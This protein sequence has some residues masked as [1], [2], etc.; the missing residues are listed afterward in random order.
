MAKPARKWLKLFT[1]FLE[2]LRIESKHESAE[3]EEKGIKLN[4]WESQQRV[5]D[6]IGNGL[7]DGVHVF[8]I[9]KSRQLGVSTVTLAILLFWAL[10]HP[11]INCAMVIDNEENSQKFRAMITKYFE[12]FPQNYFG[13]RLT[14]TK[15][16]SRT[17]EFSN[18]SS[19]D[20]LVAG[21]SKTTWGE[22]RAYTAALLSEVSKYGKPEGLNSFIETLSETNPIRLYLYESTAHGPNHWRDMWKDAGKDVY[23]K[24]PVFIGWWSSQ[25]NRFERKDPRFKIF[26]SSAPSPH[27]KEKI[28]AVWNQ[29]NFKVTQE[30]LAWYRWR[31]SSEATTQD[32]LDEQQPWTEEEAFVI[33]AMSF[34][35]VREVSKDIQRVREGVLFMGF[36]FY[37]G[38][39]FLSSTIDQ[40][41]EQHQIHE[42]ELRVWEGPVDQGRYAIGMDVAY[43][44]SEKNDS[45]CVSV[46][47]CFANK[48]VQVAEYT[49][50]R[51]S[52]QQ[53]AWVLAYL[54][55]RYRNCMVN[56]EVNGPGDG[57]MAEINSLRHQL[58]AEEYNAFMGTVNIDSSMLDCL[59]WYIYRRPDS[60]GPGFIFNFNTTFRTKLP[61]IS[62]FR[63]NHITNMLIINSIPCLE[64][65][66]HVT[67]DG[68]EVGAAAAGLH[69]DRVFAAAL[70]NDTWNK[71][72]RP[73]MMHQNLTYEREMNMGDPVKAQISDILNNA[74]RRALAAPEPPPPQ[75]TFMQDRGLV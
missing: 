3:G 17:I 4:L 74:V 52:A 70:A 38:N 48:L 60:P 9:L 54:A 39:S 53:A 12:S 58:R 7:D 30:Q 66:L 10:I 18:G 27:E 1:K 31:Q 35:Q 40:L 19:I 57:V 25:V 50:P 71:H 56:L 63:D 51:H 32:M 55:G 14:I 28:D 5:L 75:A 11:R 41:T 47:R 33:S 73:Q 34:F 49:S 46:W 16:N 15:N 2:N 8:Y 45:T 29:Y 72:I 37:L 44:R 13:D 22:S 59:R 24:R 65:M 23:S 43:G 42:V 61:L 20:F 62:D 69:D 64:E 26:G 68:R 6:A 36:R 67:Q 21:K